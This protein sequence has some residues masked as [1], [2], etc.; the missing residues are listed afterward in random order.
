MLEEHLTGLVQEIGQL[1]V[2]SERAEVLE[3][4]LSERDEQIAQLQAE[5]ARLRAAI[6][7]GRPTALAAAAAAAR[8]RRSPLLGPRR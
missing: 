3:R 4:Q 2:L 7:S 1:K 5:V 8:V 6:S